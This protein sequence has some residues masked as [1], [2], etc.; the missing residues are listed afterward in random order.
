MKT[1]V[2]LVPC[3]FTDIFYKA[4]NLALNLADQNDGSVV[5]LHLIS[6]KSERIEAEHKMDKVIDGLSESHRS[7]T[8]ARVLLGEIYQDVAFAGA[9]LDAELIIMSTHGARG[10]QKIRGS[11]ALRMVDSSSVPF[12]ITQG[13]K[14]VQ[15]INTIVMPFCYERESLQVAVSAAKLAQQCNSVV[16][17]VGYLD[18]DSNFQGKALANH[19]ILLKYFNDHNIEVVSHHIQEKEDYEEAL[20]AYAKNVKADVI[21][22]TFFNTTIFSGINNFIQ[23]LLENDDDIPVLT[24]NAE[25]LGVSSVTSV[26]M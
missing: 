18:S 10:F 17:L 7:K 16:H 1:P 19:K 5:V 9:I 14:T 26:M 12:L 22:A 11:H 15:D 13:M 8:R 2:Y 6:K 3:D 25:E 20:L 21:A 4:L 23:S 24:V